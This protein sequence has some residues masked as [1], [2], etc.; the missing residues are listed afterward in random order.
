MRKS[1]HSLSFFLFILCALMHLFCELP[2]AQAQTP[3][4]KEKIIVIH[5][6]RGTVQTDD[7]CTTGDIKINEWAKPLYRIWFD[8]NGNP[9]DGGWD[10]GQRSKQAEI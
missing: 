9:E 10:N 7:P 8:I 1:K 5:T 3:E 4:E 2:P 6:V